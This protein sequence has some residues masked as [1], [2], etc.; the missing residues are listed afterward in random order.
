MRYVRHLKCRVGVLAHR[1]VYVPRLMV[2]EYAHPTNYRGG[3]L[4]FRHTSNIGWAYSPANAPTVPRLMVGEYAHPTNYRGGALVVI[5]RPPAFECP[6]I[7]VKA[8]DPRGAF[9]IWYEQTSHIDSDS[10]ADCRPH[11]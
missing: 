5:A 6:T 4:V 9:G 3:V 1:R 7:V 11:L 8:R 2:G 10:P